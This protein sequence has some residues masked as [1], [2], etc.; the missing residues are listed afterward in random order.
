[1]MTIEDEKCDVLW[2]LLL[3]G[4]I[5]LPSLKCE[6]FADWL[7]IT[8]S[9]SITLLLRQNLCITLREKGL[10][11]IGPC[12]TAFQELKQALTAMPILVAPCDNGQ[13]VLDTDASDTA[14]GAVLQQ[15]Q[16]ATACHR[17]C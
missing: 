16:G 5:Q 1:M 13:Y 10:S 17:L 12:E 9:L 6:L 3:H 2:P 14:V 8:A 11:L 15:E 7:V 4:P